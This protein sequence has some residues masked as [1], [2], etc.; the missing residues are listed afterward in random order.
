MNFEDWMLHRGLSQSTAEKYAGAISGSLSE[1]AM[2]AGLLQGPLVAMESPAKYE[3]VSTEI[4]KLPI[5]IERNKRGHNMY[6]SAL[7]RFAG[8]LAEGFENDLESDIETVLADP[9]ASPTEKLE[10]VKA[11]V[12]QGV[13]RQKLLS[14]WQGCAITAYKE[15]TLLVA[16]H[17]K[18]WRSS[19][20]SERL[21]PFNGLLLLPNLDRAFDRGLVT[22][23][24]DGALLVSPL[25]SEPKTLGVTSGMKVALQPKHQPYM[26]FHRTSVYRA[27]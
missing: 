15:V 10:L 1:W 14:H 3:A 19:T 26:K 11:R 5:F 17:I 6:S 2:S 23:D 16:S 4:A 22:F 24:E 18:P 27:K 7:A 13:F 9:I 8:Y 21:D 25:L 20:N 12:G